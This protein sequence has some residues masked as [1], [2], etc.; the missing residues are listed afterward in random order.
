[1][2]INGKTEGIELHDVLAVAKHY[3]IK[4]PKGIIERVEQALALWPELAAKH[5][6]SER[7]VTIIFTY[8]RQLLS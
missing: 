8:F 7:N 5:K 1:M 3:G 6:L 4:R 2:A